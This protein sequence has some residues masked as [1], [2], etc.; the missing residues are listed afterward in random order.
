MRALLEL[1]KIR[2]NLKKSIY[3]PISQ[4]TLEKKLETAKQLKEFIENSLDENGEELTTLE[5]NQICKETRHIALEISEIIK[6]KLATVKMTSQNPFDLKM[7]T[8]LVQPYDGSPTNLDSFVDSVVLLTELTT[9][10]QMPVAVKFVK[11]RL[12]GKA[13]STLPAN[14]D[15]LADIINSVKENCA[16]RETPQSVAAKLKSLVKTNDSAKFFNDVE[17]LT[18]QL[19]SLYV[20]EEIP[21]NTATKMATKIGIETI[22]NKITDHDTKLI[23]K[24]SEFPSIQAAIQKFNENT[25]NTP[26]AQIFSAQA[27]NS[28]NRGRNNMR[29]NSNYRG[30]N[31]NS[32]F[33]GNRNQYQNSNHSRYPNQRQ[34]YSRGR[35]NFNQPNRYQQQYDQRNARVFYTQP[36][37]ELPG[38]MINNGNMMQPQQQAPQSNMQQ[39]PSG[40]PFVNTLGQFSR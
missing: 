14:V 21:L 9:A 35:G 26:S 12:N 11:T 5:F 13:R 8:A 15:S 10:A 2:D 33:R 19:T 31:R 30:G 17:Q 25:T 32:N 24:A 23:M 38:Q 29:G 36:M 18:T 28:H 20:K 7:A 22:I 37:Q 3:K 6:R 40:H 39:H 34:N 4:Q 16:S 27:R 1:K